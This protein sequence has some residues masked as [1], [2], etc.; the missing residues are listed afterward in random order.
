MQ[1]QSLITLSPVAEGYL[2]KMA[3]KH[4]AK[5]IKI[6]LEKAGC[7]GYMYHIDPCSVCPEHAFVQQISLN[8]TLFIPRESIARL[9]GSHLDYKKQDLSLKAVF[10]N[11]NTRM[12][13]GCGDSVELIEKE[14]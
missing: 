4:Q 7:A 12:A 11:P 13:C 14:Q 9:R 2:E 10:T 1:E 5:G 8:L 3:K 6:A